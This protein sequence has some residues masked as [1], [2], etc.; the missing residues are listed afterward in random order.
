MVKD[1]SPDD[2]DAVLNDLSPDDNDVGLN[3]ASPDDNDTIV[4]DVSPDDNDASPDL[5]TMLAKTAPRYFKNDRPFL[6][7]PTSWL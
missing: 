3:N 6:K 7:S 1:A 4:N 5:Y 2:N